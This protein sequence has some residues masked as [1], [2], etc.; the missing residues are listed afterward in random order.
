M[1]VSDSV[2]CLTVLRCKQ[3]SWDMEQLLQ[4]TG[5][6]YEAW[7]TAFNRWTPNV[8]YSGETTTDFTCTGNCTGFSSHSCLDKIQTN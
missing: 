2:G 6:Q 8:I 1:V 4:W 7:I 3:G 5:H